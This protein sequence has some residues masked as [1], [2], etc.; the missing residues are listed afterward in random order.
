MPLA[1][2]QKPLA[3]HLLPQKKK[4]I[5]ETVHLIVPEP[6]WHWYLD[7]LWANQDFIGTIKFDPEKTD[8]L[9]HEILLKTEDPVYI[10]QFK[11]PNAHQ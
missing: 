9:L 1:W 10:K 5:T 6:Y 7:V 8:T 4:F 11:I 3:S 2:T